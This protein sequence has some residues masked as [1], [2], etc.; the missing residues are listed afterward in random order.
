LLKIIDNL[1][2]SGVSECRK[3][4]ERNKGKREEVL[5]KRRKEIK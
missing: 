1:A 4:R 5:V 3:R 2:I